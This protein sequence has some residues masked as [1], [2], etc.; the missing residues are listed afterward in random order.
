MLNIAE[1][2]IAPCTG[3]ELCDDASECNIDDDMQQ[4]YSK[5]TEAEGI[6]IGTLVYFWSV[7]GQIK[8]FIDRTYALWKGK[9][10]RG[11]AGGIAVVARHAGGG[12]AYALVN[13]FFA[14]QRMTLAGGV[15][16]YADKEGDIREDKQ[17]MAEA[18]TA[19]RAM[20]RTIKKLMI[21][22]K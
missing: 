6:F 11:K 17:G 5:L 22:A 16:G 20:V 7:S 3:C 13:T 19:G 9:K 8:V 21:E 18:R 4:L 2:D 15:L 10:L 1:K 14:I 12:N